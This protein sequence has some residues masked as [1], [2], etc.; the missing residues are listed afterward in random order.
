MRAGEFLRNVAAS[1]IG[2][3][4]IAG[5]WLAMP[6]LASQLPQKGA[7]LTTPDGLGRSD[8]QAMDGLGLHQ[9]ADSSLLW[10]LIAATIVVFVARRL[11][12]TAL[13]RHASGDG[14]AA[15]ETAERLARALG[16]T[17]GA[18]GARRIRR[19]SDDRGVRIE[20]GAM[21]WGR[22]LVSVAAAGLV[23]A[24]MW[25]AAEPPAELFEVPLR[26]PGTQ[27]GV[28]A[29]VGEAGHLVA[30]SGRRAAACNRR[31]GGLACDLTIDGRPQKLDLTA[32][33]A[34]RV[35]RRQVTW[36][37]NALDPDQPDGRLHWRPE[38]TPDAP[39]YAFNVI[40]D[41]MLKIDSLRAR[42]TLL[43]TNRAG[44]V[45]FGARGEGASAAI[46]VQ[47]A[48]ELLPKGVPAARM[49]TTARVRLLVGP[50]LPALVLI[51]LLALAGIGAVLLFAVPGVELAVSA[52]DGTVAV[53]SCN[54]PE[55]LAVVQ[56]AAPPRVTDGG[57]A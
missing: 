52:V 27:S 7:P 4:L 51:L 5:C 56:S 20:L 40:A 43:A 25:T 36:L 35:G 10:L 32:G 28:A 13:V 23:T 29:Y 2:A 1:H 53:Q 17:D 12:P 57:A 55:L 21:R 50:D 18:S 16:G 6:L 14:A 37:A 38:S 49:H 22:R 8:L 34:V 41:R 26:A 11:F 46:F 24:L 45:V 15:G 30:A 9:L 48:P 3:R 47:A 19:I 54:R 33:S 42:L 39:W 31:G 44:P